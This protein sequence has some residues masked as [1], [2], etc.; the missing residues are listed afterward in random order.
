MVYRASF[1]IKCLKPGN[2]T[3]ELELSKDILKKHNWYINNKEIFTLP[4]K[5]DVRTILEIKNKA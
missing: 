5:E 4:N 3:E 2:V 1:K